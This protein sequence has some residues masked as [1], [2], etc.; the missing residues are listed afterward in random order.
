M[1]LSPAWSPTGAWAARPP[2]RL[3]KRLAH[4]KAANAR[5]SS[6]P[7]PSAAPVSYTHLRAHETSAHL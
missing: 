2:G 4:G 3:S 7:L 5:S 6:Q 1:D